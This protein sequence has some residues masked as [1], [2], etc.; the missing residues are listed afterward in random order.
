MIARVFPRKTTATPLD[1]YAFVG[2]PGLFIPDDITEIHVS[3]T[4]T[5]DIPLAERL[6]RIWERYAPVK[7]GGPA[8]GDQGETF[9]P[10][11]YLKRGNVITSRGCNN[12]C[13]FC[14]V[15]KREG[16][17]RELPISEGNNLLDNN[18]LGCSA[19]HIRAV[20]EM[21]KGQADA[22]LTGGIEA[23]IL[24]PW[25]VDLMAEAK[26]Q[27]LFCAYDTPDDL[28][29]LIEAAKMFK[30]RSDWYSWRKCGCYC[31]IGYPNDTI[32]KAEKRLITTLKLGYKPFAMFYRDAEGKN[33]KTPEWATLQREWTRPAI[34][35]AIRK[36][37]LREVIP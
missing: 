19:A 6:A 22:R 12:K 4:F 23:K 11:M 37:L 14:L 29:P 26:I 10:G 15:P 30:E 3:V 16:K 7:V 18:I 33:I 25:H 36:K 31:L 21:L 20:F 2:E 35:N 17:L 1:E 28:E 5:W 34:I 24:Q 13:W 8:Y 9:T 27:Q 32:E